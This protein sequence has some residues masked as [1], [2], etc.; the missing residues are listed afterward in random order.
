MPKKSSKKIIPVRFYSGDHVVFH[1]KGRLSGLKGVVIEQYIDKTQDEIGYEVL[2]YDEEDETRD[3]CAQVMTSN[4]EKF[5]PDLAYPPIF[6]QEDSLLLGTGWNVSLAWKI[7]KADR[8]KVPV[9]RKFIESFY[10]QCF[11]GIDEPEVKLE[12]GYTRIPF[13]LIDINKEIALSDKTDLSIP[14]IMVKLKNSHFPIDGRHRLYKAYHTN[15]PIDAY[16]LTEAEERII[17]L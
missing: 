4:L 1:G 3:V 9:P 17:K 5:E 14:I 2:F 7:I 11:K 12:G 15:Q 10:N 16:L 6:P 8:E 13:S